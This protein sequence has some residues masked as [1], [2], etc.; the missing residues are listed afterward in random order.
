MSLV[1][2]TRL[3]L[4][5]PAP[6]VLC[7]FVTDIAKGIIGSLIKA[8]PLAVFNLGNNKPETLTSMVDLLT[9]ALGLQGN[10]KV[11]HEPQ[12]LGASTIM[13][14]TLS[15]TCQQSS[16]CVHTGDV[17][18]TYASN[19]LAHESFGFM[20]SIDLGPGLCEF[21]MWYAKF[22]GGTTPSCTRPDLV[23]QPALEELASARRSV[24]LRP[25]G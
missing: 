2:T 6:V 14:C 23:P 10:V 9:D 22:Y 3:L 7:R 12:P 19:T 15:A 16:C 25:V 4:P 20:P 17:T 5:G 21:A 8:S 18:R 11:R 24:V 13:T 1:L